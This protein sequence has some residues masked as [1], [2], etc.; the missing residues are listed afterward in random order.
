MSSRIRC[1][2]RLAA[3]GL[4]AA[5]LLGGAAP[6]LESA[7]PAGGFT[8]PPDTP[9]IPWLR[10]SIQYAVR[11]LGN[12]G[13]SSIFFYV[14]TDGGLTWRLLGEDPDKKSPML[15][16]VPSEGTYGFATVVA[17]GHRKPEP[18]RPGTR[19]D[20]FVIVDR[21]PPSVTWISPVGQ[22]VK[23]T[24]DGILLEWMAQDPH[25]G[26]GPVSIDYSTDGGALWL[27]V[28]QNLPA[29]GSINWKV[30]PMGEKSVQLRLTA[31]DLA[32]NTRVVR[33]RADIAV[34]RTPPTVR[35]TSPDV[36]GTRA[37]DVY[38]EAEDE[39]GVATVD[40]YYTNDHG[41][42]WAFFGSA[43]SSPIHFAGDVSGDAV[44]LYL[45][46]AD[47]RGNRTEAP[48]AGTP[49]MKV[50][51]L[52]T[53][54]P[55][56]SLLAPFNVSGH[57]VAAGQPTTVSWN[58]V[59]SHPEE[60][61]AVIEYS[62]DGGGQWYLA[63]DRQPVSGSY[64]WTPP[65]R[66]DNALLRVTVSDKYGNKGAALS[67]IFRI[68]AGRPGTRI[69]DVTPIPGAA[70]ASG[71]SDLERELGTLDVPTIPSTPDV[72]TD[73][74]DK[75][76]AID[77]GALNAL[78][79]PGAVAK[80]APA[81]PA[82]PSANDDKVATSPANE[83][84][85]I[86]LP[87]ETKIGKE[88]DFG[89]PPLPGVDAPATGKDGGKKEEKK[90]EKDPFGEFGSIPPIGESDAG[91]NPP[92]LTLPTPGLDTKDDAKKAPN[93]TGLN[94]PDIPA[95]GASVEKAPATVPPVV[96]TPAFDAAAAI[97]K[98]NAALAQPNGQGLAEAD[99]LANEIITQDP[100]NAAPYAIMAQVRTNQGKFAEAEN[101]AN[102][103][104]RL[105]PGDFNYM[106]ILGYA[107]YAHANSLYSS[108]RSGGI[109]PGRQQAAS[110]DMV[111]ALNASETTY[112]QLLKAP[113]KAKVK[114]AY[115]RLGH[116]DYFRGTKVLTDEAQS[117]E[118]IRKAIVNYQKA[119]EINEPAY[120]EYLQTGICNY[121][122]RDYDQAERW[123]ERAIEVANND[124]V[125]P[126]EAYYYLASIHEKRDRP[127][128]ALEYWEKVAKEYPA[129][130]QFQKT[131]LEH[132]ADLKAGK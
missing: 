25:M 77:E 100:N 104:C 98:A 14:T 94:I 120:R 4:T 116:I 33:N 91:K 2:Q 15:V 17:S 30:P 61:S 129:G 19:P 112:L 1:W 79:T 84:P 7:I 39:S 11:I 24:A 105:A 102:N 127:Q 96:P 21:T 8:P 37:F 53:E 117:T 27:P 130:N 50:V 101:F 85:S 52:D 106:E 31:K 46:A 48:R 88:E 111:K 60:N 26:A 119:S 42:A 65:E 32:G 81:T 131:A 51:G 132:I 44:G 38:Y 36:S 22:N 75:I 63:A 99:R 69:S 9:V 56:V 67:Q 13:P 74:N 18:P 95:P 123:L 58:T 118:C 49:P 122:L 47:K 20:K 108:I 64:S 76:G 55:Q 113:D 92:P 57:A 121:R 97:A 124:Q 6:A 54:K 40:L 83:I 72:L 16:T 86:P 82:A 70:P 3:A 126:K 128:Q 73:S 41:N 107:E 12:D 93:P 28:R 29:K 10:F 78:P 103:A 34:D 62:V 115:F 45:A 114:N 87:G 5:L 110:A 90:E 43:E 89:L 125:S 66:A 80:P 109:A 23:A 35:I 71:Q 59:E 68:D